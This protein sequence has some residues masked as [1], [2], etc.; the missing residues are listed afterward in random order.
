M[1]VI[2]QAPEQKPTPAVEGLYCFIAFIYPKL[3]TCFAADVPKAP[4]SVVCFYEEI[5]AR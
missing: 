5:Y 3:R 2:S 1:G 4:A